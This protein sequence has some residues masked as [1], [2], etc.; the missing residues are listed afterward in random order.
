MQRMWDE[1]A[2]TRFQKSPAPLRPPQSSEGFTG[3]LGVNLSQTQSCCPQA[4]A[5][6]TLGQPRAGQPHTSF[7]TLGAGTAGLRA[8]FLE[9][10]PLELAGDV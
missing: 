9:E 7:P 3:G 8:V 2:P 4:G 1:T 6:V 5:A 10:E